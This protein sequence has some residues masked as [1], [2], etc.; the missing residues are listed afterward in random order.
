MYAGGEQ[1]MNNKIREIINN[2][3][4]KIT[5]VIEKTGISKSHF[6]DIMNGKAVPSLT[7]AAKISEVLKVPLTEL[8]PSLFTNN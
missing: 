2:K 7:N 6:Y 4:L 1:N 5:Y 8:F 3:G